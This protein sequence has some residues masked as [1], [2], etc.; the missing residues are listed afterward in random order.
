[1][2]ITIAYLHLGRAM[3]LKLDKLMKQ[4]AR[5]CTCVNVGFAWASLHDRPDTRSRSRTCF[6]KSPPSS[7]PQ[8]PTSHFQQPHTSTRLV[9]ILQHRQREETWLSRRTRPCQ[10]QLPAP[11]P[12]LT[13]NSPPRF[14][15]TPRTRVS[16]HRSRQINPASVSRNRESCTL[17]TL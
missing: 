8:L 12:P 16:P 9:T 10:L 6:S 3:H 4:R 2:I 7:Y 1:M 17:E 11:H 5:T 15:C 13:R 14:H